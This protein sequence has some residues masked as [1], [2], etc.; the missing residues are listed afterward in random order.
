MA[1]VQAAID[2][3]EP[4]AL[5]LGVRGVGDVEPLEKLED[6]RDLRDERLRPAIDQVREAHRGAAD[7][8]VRARDPGD[9][10]LEI[11]KLA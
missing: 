1:R 3:R 10:V 4:L 5:A 8:V 9:L 7:P 6:L 11:G 2:P